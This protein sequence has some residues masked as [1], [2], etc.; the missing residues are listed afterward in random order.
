MVAI[1]ERYC[2]EQGLSVFDEIER[3]SLSGATLV[4]VLARNRPARETSW[5]RKTRGAED[6]GAQ[7]SKI[8]TYST[9]N[10]I[11]LARSSAAV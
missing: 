8:I 7:R 10:G 3:I 1:P 4:G 5:T 2:I 6:T 11:A 9:E